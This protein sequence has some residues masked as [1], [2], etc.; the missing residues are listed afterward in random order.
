[1]QIL[2]TKFREVHEVFWKVEQR[3]DA[4]WSEVLRYLRRATEDETPHV[5]W[6]SIH[7]TCVSR[8]SGSLVIWRRF[9]NR[10]IISSDWELQQFSQC[11]DWAMG[12][13]TEVQFA[14]RTGIFSAP[15]RVQTGSWAHS[16]SC[17][18]GYRVLF[19]GSKEAESRSWPLTTIW[20]RRYESLELYLHSL[21]MS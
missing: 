17:P 10:I 1:V 2:D 3:D 5:S 4:L 9:Y 7:G 19:P 21:N 16:A 11:S 18:V 6:Y 20:Y 14:A 12:W 13:T 8:W 15:H